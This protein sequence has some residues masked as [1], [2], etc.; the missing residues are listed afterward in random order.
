[1]ISLLNCLGKI[2]EKIA[3]EAISTYCEAAGVLHSGQMGSRKR[4]S[5]ID[6]VACLIQKVRVAWSGK[7]LVDALFIDVKGVFLIMWT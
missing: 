6:A 5:A 2:V 4:C 7:R 3:A 1:M